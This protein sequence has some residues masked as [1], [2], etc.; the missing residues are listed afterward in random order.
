MTI[1]VTGADGYMGWPLM[2][3]LAKELPDERIVGIDNFA[4]RKWVER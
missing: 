1:L 2:L 3:K 4:R